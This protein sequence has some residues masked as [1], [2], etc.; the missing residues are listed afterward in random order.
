VHDHASAIDIADLQACELGATHAGAVEGH[1]N[2][3]IEGSRRSID[4]LSHFFLTENG[5]QT[6]ALLGIG[7]VGN[8]P[9]TLEDLD[10]DEIGAALLRL[11]GFAP[12]SRGHG[13]WVVRAFLFD[14]GR[15]S[16]GC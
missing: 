2:G 7:T 1:Q 13:A 14:S 8:T 15:I 3:A 12:G 4:E 9:G 10:V 5:G 16:R 6:I 11:D